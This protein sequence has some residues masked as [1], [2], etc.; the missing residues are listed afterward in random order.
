M[1][2]RHVCLPGQYESSRKSGSSRALLDAV[3]LVILSKWNMVLF[4]AAVSPAKESHSSVSLLVRGTKFWPV[5]WKLLG[6]Y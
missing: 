4:G 2:L 6:I 5:E 3:L 1:C